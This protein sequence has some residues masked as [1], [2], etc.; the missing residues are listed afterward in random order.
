MAMTYR[1]YIRELCDARDWTLK[2]LQERAN[3]AR[4]TAQRWYYNAG[5][6]SRLDAPV[7]LEF[8]RVFEVESIID[9]IRP[10]IYDSL[11]EEPVS[12]LT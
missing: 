3:I 7:V 2:D 8:M 12:V 4:G 10:Q 1:T 9:I 6:I 5:E 11:T